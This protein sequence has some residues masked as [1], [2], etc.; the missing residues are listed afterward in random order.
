M[1]AMMKQ[2]QEQFAAQWAD[3]TQAPRENQQ[4]VPMRSEQPR[5]VDLLEKFTKL[6]P[7][8]FQGATNPTIAED[9]LVQVEKVLEAMNCPDNQ[10]V[11]LASFILQGELDV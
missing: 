7:P 10:K 9:W 6:R 8:A 5:E 11:R 4:T 2:Q 1:A 3:M